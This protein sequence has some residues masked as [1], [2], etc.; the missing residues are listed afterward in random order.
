VAE[1]AP[2]FNVDAMDTMELIFSSS[3][4]TY[5]AMVAASGSAKLQGRSEQQRS[6]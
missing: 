6:A 3:L 1:S 5:S 4:R 2:K